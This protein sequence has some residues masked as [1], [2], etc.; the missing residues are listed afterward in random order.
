MLIAKE[1]EYSN[2]REWLKKLIIELPND[3]I[4]NET[5]GVLENLTLYEMSIDRIITTKPTIKDNKM[6]VNISIYGAAINISGIINPV[7]TSSN[8]R[9][10]WSVI[11]KQA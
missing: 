5:K 10:F 4:K 8:Y 7:I 3:L 11:Q 2:L 9:F 6:G 1:T